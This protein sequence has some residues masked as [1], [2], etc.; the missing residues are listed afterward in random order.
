MTDQETIARVLSGEKNAYADLVRAHQ[1]EIFRLCVSLLGNEAEAED[2]AQES[3]LKAYRA[4][5]A[6]RQDS[7]FSTWLYRIAYRQ[8][9]DLLR[10]RTRRKADSLEKLLEEHGDAIQHL[11]ASPEDHSRLMENRELVH[12]LLSTL[13]P[14]YRNALYLR[15]MHGLTYA[16]IAAV[17][18]TSLDGVKARL[19]RARK[20]LREK[21]R[22]F[23]TPAGV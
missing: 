21:M 3:F 18:G 13:S 16:E 11:F 17:M 10:F 19:R 5:A 4:L 23:L 1:D 14:D 22:H 6:F 8:C 9:L 12:R 2:A 7:S 15:E 20:F